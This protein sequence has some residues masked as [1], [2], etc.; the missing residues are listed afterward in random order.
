MCKVFNLSSA[1]A[2]NRELLEA[3]NCS[4]AGSWLN[5]DVR[6]TAGRLYVPV[7]VIFKGRRRTKYDIPPFGFNQITCSVCSPVDG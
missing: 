3:S 1:I 2:S 7:W 6:H 5:T 4:S